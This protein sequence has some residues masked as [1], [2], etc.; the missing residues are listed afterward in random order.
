MRFNEIQDSKVLYIIDQPQ[1]IDANYLHQAKQLIAQGGEIAPEYINAGIDRSHMVAIAIANDQVVAV[2]AAKNPNPSYRNRV[3][4]AAGVANLENQYPLESGYSYTNP[5]WR[6]SNISAQLHRKLFA[7]I[8]TPMFA[9]VREQNRVAL[10]GLQ[11]L[12]FRPI[13]NTFTS[14][15]GN[16]EIV[17]L[18]N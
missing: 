12:G 3:F 13:G 11:R 1:N 2:T 6:N 4:A 7:A 5:A 14:P 8:D 15:R 10:L 16:Y 17:L 9:T 18:V